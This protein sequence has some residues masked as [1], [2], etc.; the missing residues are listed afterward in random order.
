MLVSSMLVSC[1]DDDSPQI[2]PELNKT[3]EMISY[4]AFMPEIPE[5]NEGDILWTIDIYNKKLTVENNIQEQYPYM[6]PSGTYE[7]EITYNT[8]TTSFF[9]YD[10]NIQDNTLIVSDEW[11]SDD[12]PIMKFVATQ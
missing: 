11:E 4:V 1:S 6:T 8:I 5:I 2:N 7:I 12:G 10:Y 9:E 3:W